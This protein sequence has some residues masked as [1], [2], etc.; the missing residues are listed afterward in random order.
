MRVTIVSPGFPPLPGGGERYARALALHLAA[1]GCAVT[2]VAGSAERE[3]AFWQGSPTRS[4]T[5]DGPL[6]VHRLPIA[7]WPGG[8]SALLA[9]RK[10]MVLLSAL[11]APPVGLLR[12]LGRR[13]P[14]I[15]DLATTLATLP[16]PDVIHA[17]NLSWESG[18]LAAAEQSARCGAPLIVTPFAH[19]GDRPRG[20]LARNTM[21]AHQ[22]ALLEQASAVLTLTEV[23]Q[24]GFAAWGVQPRRVVVI[25]GGSDALPAEAGRLP[26]D[27]P[28]PCVLFIGRLNRDKGALDAVAAV[29]QLNRRGLTV[30]LALVG[31]TTPEFAR[32]YRRLSA[33]ERRLIRPLGVLSDADKHALLAACDLLTLPSH[34][35]SFGIVLLEAWAHGKPVVAARAG[36]IPS[37]V[38]DG[39]DGLL[40][41]YGDPAALADALTDLLTNPARRHTMGAAGR[42]QLAARFNWAT[43][44][45]ATLAAYEQARAAAATHA[46][47]APRPPVST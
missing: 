45:Q 24:V 44:A 22:R 20:R 41:P 35:E 27:L 12:R 29:Q 17:F 8:R 15:P 23:E 18:L 28:R 9:A 26:D 40:V 3:A 34:S 13:F 43:V 1:L 21:M 39:V 33:A 37:L 7:P 10:A 46:H 16:A 38:R 32:A 11:P 5:Q 4:F 30:G 47:S 36:G 19:F 42:A 6:S 31:Q 25:G 2:V 14:H